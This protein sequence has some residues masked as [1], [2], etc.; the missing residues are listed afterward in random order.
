[1]SL[2]QRITVITA[3]V[4]VAGPLSMSAAHASDGDSGPGGVLSNLAGRN[5]SGHANLCGTGQAGSPEGP[6]LQDI[7]QE[8]ATMVTT[9]DHPVVACCLTCCTPAMPRCHSNNCGN[10]AVSALSKTTCVVVDAP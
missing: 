7:R 9:R 8:G 6:D 5:S 2:V 1:M 10:E 3:T 4:M